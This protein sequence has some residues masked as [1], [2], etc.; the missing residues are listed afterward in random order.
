MAFYALNPK[1]FYAISI[2]ITY[3]K[4]TQS[5]KNKEKGF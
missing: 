5:S 4:L 1:I 3:D 2:R